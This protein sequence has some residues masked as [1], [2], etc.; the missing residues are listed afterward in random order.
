GT[1]AITTSGD[2]SYVLIRTEQIGLAE[3]S[4]SPS[5]SPGASGQ[6]SAS[7]SPAASASPVSSAPAASGSPGAVAS[8]T[9]STPSP[10]PT[11]GASASASPGAVIPASPAPSASPGTGGSAV[12][13]P[14]TGKLADLRFAFED[15]FGPIDEVRQEANIGPI[16]S[17]EIAQQ[18]L[19]LIVLGSI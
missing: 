10:S 13:L 16:I 14:T 3:F 4:P 12:N 8:T 2:K 1:A 11:P 5:A 17:N 19:L 15:E 18:A 9:A 7:G 6:P